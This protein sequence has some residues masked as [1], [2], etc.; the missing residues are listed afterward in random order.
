MS[1]EPIAIN[2]T[3]HP[4]AWVVDLAKREARDPRGL[5]RFQQLAWREVAG[6]SKATTAADWLAERRAMRDAARAS[7]QEARQTQQA[8]ETQ[9]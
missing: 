3:V 1:R 4:R 9:A 7:S 8:Q 5:T 2:P 6:V